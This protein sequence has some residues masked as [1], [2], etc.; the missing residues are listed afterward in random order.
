VLQKFK[1]QNFSTIKSSF[2]YFLFAVR[3]RIKAFRTCAFIGVRVNFCKRR[4]ERARSVISDSDLRS[5]AGGRE[6]ECER[7]E[8]RD[9][10]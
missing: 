8:W 10:E 4:M 5:M 3:Y 2:R 1:F 6:G 7:G 9:R